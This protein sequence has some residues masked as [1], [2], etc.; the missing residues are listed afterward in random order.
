MSEILEKDIKTLINKNKI[1]LNV[2]I[3]D[4]LDNYDIILVEIE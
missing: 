4:E 2:S 3:S 1:V